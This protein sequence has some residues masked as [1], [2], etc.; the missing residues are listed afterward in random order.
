MSKLFIYL[1]QNL[2]IDLPLSRLQ[3]YDVRMEN[4]TAA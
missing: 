1:K 4:V 3:K 2:I